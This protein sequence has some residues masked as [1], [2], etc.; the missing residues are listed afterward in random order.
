MI[1]SHTEN[2]ARM[3]YFSINVQHSDSIY[4]GLSRQMRE[5]CP[6]SEGQAMIVACLTLSQSVSAAQHVLALLWHP[7]PILATGES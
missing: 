1:Q 4:A 3:K 7:L 5:N 2:T 6:G